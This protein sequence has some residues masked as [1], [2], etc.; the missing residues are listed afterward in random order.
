MEKALV[1]KEKQAQEQKKLEQIAAVNSAAEAKLAAAAKAKLD[2]ELAAKAKVEADAKSK[3]EL[4]A[5]FGKLASCFTL[6][7]RSS[8]AANTISP[9][10]SNAT[11]LSW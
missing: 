11:E 8:W 1:E 2:A 5:C 4:K 10:L 6:V 3:A 7:K 9:F